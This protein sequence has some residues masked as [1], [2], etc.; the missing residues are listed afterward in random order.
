MKK[1]VLQSLNVAVFLVSFL[2]CDE[3]KKTAWVAQLRKII[4]EI[5][6]VEPDEEEE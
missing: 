5:Q 4:I 2:K 1:I 6:T 3:K